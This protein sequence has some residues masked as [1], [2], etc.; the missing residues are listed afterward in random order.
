M[1]DLIVLGGGITGYSL[2]LRAA[3]RGMKVALVESRSYLGREMTATAHAWLRNGQSPY[4]IYTPIGAQKKRMLRALLDLNVQLLL[5]STPVGLLMDDGRAVGVAIAN[6]FGIQA[7]YG[8]N[9][10]DAT[11][12]FS[13]MAQLS[14][15]PPAN[16]QQQEIRYILTVQGIKPLF[17][18]T[19]DVNGD[20]IKVFSLP[21]ANTV[22]LEICFNAAGSRTQLESRARKKALETYMALR[23]SHPHFANAQLADLANEIRLPFTPCPFKGC[24]GLLAFQVN[25]N[26][27]STN[28]FEACE[29]AADDWLDTLAA[30]KSTLC[31]NPTLLMHGEPIA[32]E[33]AC[34]AQGMPQGVS[35]IRLSACPPSF[36]TIETD[37][38]VAG[39]GS[40]G[41]FAAMGLQEKGVQTLMVS[42]FYDAGGTRTIGRVSGTYFGYQGGKAANVS[43]AVKELSGKMG[44]EGGSSDRIARILCYHAMMEGSSVTALSGYTACGALCGNGRLQAVLIAGEDGLT[45]VRAKQFLDATSDGD[46]AALA[47]VGFDVGCPVDGQVMTNGQWGDSH[48]QLT[49][50]TDVPYRT[51]FDIIH[52]DYYSELLRAIYTAHGNNSDIDFSPLNTLRET[53]RIH[54]QHDLSLADIFLQRAFPDVIAVA[55]TPYDTHGRASSVLLGMGMLEFNEAPIRSRVPLACSIPTGLGALLVGGK[56]IGG[57]R[58]GNSLRRMNADSENGGYALGLTLAACIEQSRDASSVDLHGVQNALKANGCLPSWAECTPI[59]ARQAAQML[60]E[61]KKNGLLYSLLQPKEEML[62]LLKKQCGTDALITLAWFGDD[63]ATEAC[64]EMLKA[65]DDIMDSTVLISGQDY[66]MRP[67]TFTGEAGKYHFINRLI[68]LLGCKAPPNAFDALLPILNR[69]TSGGMPVSGEDAYHKYRLDIHRVPFYE[70][71]AC[72]TFAVERLADPRALPA[73]T[74]LSTE[75]ELSGYLVLDSTHEQALAACAWL[76]VRLACATA[77]CGGLMGYEKLTAYL[78]DERHVLADYAFRVLCGLTGFV[79]PMEKEAWQQALASYKPKVQPCADAVFPIV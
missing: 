18:R 32:F 37:V 27:L 30:G 77:R 67:I 65:A 76:E 20:S 12:F 17:E 22:M 66:A 15:K 52:P 57:T 13:G 46:I 70:R 10:A 42:P 34:V 64:I 71:I 40:T 26:T 61:G 47:G 69:A 38:M 33:Q 72:L 55:E 62:S 5:L 73:L 44:N 23:A 60:A 16:P 25:T 63:T 19:L 50:W 8:R 4:D 75:P 36:P 79:L 43:S 78:A 1:V 9:I 35:P 14:G 6:K 59:T 3:Q 2:A 45:C 48:H 74:R 24:E 68:T 41:I 39:N 49:R 11:E 28:T 21:M 51:D 53:R 29:R 54:A 58:D 31:P 56:A 7:I